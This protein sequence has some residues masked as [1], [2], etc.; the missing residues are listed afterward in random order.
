MRI[1]L[2]TPKVVRTGN[3]A[4]SLPAGI[5]SIKESYPGRRFEKD[6]EGWET[7][8][9]SLLKQLLRHSWLQKERAKYIYHV[10]VHYMFPTLREAY[11]EKIKQPM[12]LTTVEMKLLTAAY[13][14]ADEFISDI[15]LVFANAIAFNKD[16]HDAGDAMSCA[17]YDASTHL[18]RYV[19]WLSLEVLQPYLSDSSKG[20]V[21][22]SGPAS[23]WKLTARNR[24]FAREELESI[25]FNHP[26]DKTDPDDRY[27]WSEAEC[28]KLLRSLMQTSDRKRMNWYIGMQ[29]PPDYT[30]FISRP[31]A[32]DFCQEKLK[33]RQYNTI[34][35]V[36]EDLMFHLP[37]SPPAYLYLGRTPGWTRKMFLQL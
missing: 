23:K 9:F 10:P 6:L 11:A 33:S 36:V 5:A 16:G 35:E 31:I 22:E 13:K 20:P 18:L 37:D 15:A 14:D 30:A 27:S 28:E 2:S 34:G 19:R 1:K 21:V 24:E 26:L 4:L 25:V 3:E 7:G 8:C 29:F 17:Y 12:D 32:Y